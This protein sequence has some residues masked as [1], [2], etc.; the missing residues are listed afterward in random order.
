MVELRNGLKHL[1]RNKC[2][3]SNSVVAKCFVY[4]SLELHEHVFRLFELLLVDGRVG[5]RWKHTT[6]SMIPTVYEVVGPD[7]VC[8]CRFAERVSS[9]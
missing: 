2:A 6:F 9:Y 3:D 5:E 4:G 7:V 8:Q 1:R